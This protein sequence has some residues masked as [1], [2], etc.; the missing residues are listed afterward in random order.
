MKHLKLLPLLIAAAFCMPRAQAADVV[1]QNEPSSYA[2]ALICI[3]LVMLA[4]A[5]HR[6]PA[7]FKHDN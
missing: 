3:G 4:A 5:R 2:I 6:R 1:A 7:S